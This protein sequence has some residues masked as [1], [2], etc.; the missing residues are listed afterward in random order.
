LENVPGFAEKNPSGHRQAHRFAA[1]FKHEKTNFVL[2]V[3]DLAADARLRDV[4]FGRGA[5]NILLLRYSDVSSNKEPPKK[6]IRHEN[7]IY[8]CWYRDGNVRS[9]FDNR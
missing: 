5:R 7:R 6:E 3:V 1:P 4:K 8:R 2:E 9:P